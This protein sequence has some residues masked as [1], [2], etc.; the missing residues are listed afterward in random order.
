VR[1]G[2]QLVCPAGVTVRVRQAMV[3]PEIL[4][5]PAVG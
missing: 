5:E 3:R 4:G 1:Y 2:D